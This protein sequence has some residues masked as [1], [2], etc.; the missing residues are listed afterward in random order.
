M[1]V[2]G[3]QRPWAALKLTVSCTVCLGALLVSKVEVAS[4]KSLDFMDLWALQV[5]F[6]GKEIR[7]TNTT[8]TAWCTQLKEI[9]NE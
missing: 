4:R 3:M 8:N 7:V 1:Q 9:N 5:V 6:M 2:T